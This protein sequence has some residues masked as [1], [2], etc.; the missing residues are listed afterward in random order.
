MVK[1]IHLKPQ[2][3]EFKSPRV[4]NSLG[5]VGSLTFWRGNLPFY[6]IN[7][8]F[9]KKINIDWINRFWPKQQFKNKRFLL[10]ND[11]D[12]ASKSTG[13]DNRFR[14]NFCWFG[15]SFPSS[16]STC[17]CVA[18]KLKKTWEAKVLHIMVVMNSIEQSWE[19]HP[20]MW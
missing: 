17:T 6:V 5:R 19:G 15:H 7:K 4:W 12:N 20:M 1:D 8:W 10:V 13:T 16:V 18:I 14:F 3:L 11:R 2:G 9:I